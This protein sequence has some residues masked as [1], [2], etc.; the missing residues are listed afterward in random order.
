MNKQS[1]YRDEVLKLRSKGLGYT[2]ISRIVGCT[3]STA[4]YL[5]HPEYREK[6]RTRI[7]NNPVAVL[8]RKLASFNRIKKKAN[9]PPA[10]SSIL[11]R[12]KQKMA[13]FFYEKGKEKTQEEIES[14][15]EISYDELIVRLQENPKCYLTGVDIDLNKPSTYQLDHMIPRCRGG[16]NT[17]ENMGLCTK[18]ANM[19]KN[20]MTPDEFINFCKLVVA[21]SQK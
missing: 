14:K 17:L 12:L 20:D 13:A 7:N 4:F 21:N 6:I 3:P 10:Q 9:K 18:E 19:A 5:D 8:K 11:I 1:K 15:M 16:Q 2:E